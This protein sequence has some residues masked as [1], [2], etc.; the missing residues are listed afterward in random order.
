MTDE[1]LTQE[2]ARA[3]IMAYGADPPAENGATR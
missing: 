2:R 1:L 3:L